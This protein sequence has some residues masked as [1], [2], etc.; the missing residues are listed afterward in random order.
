AELGDEQRLRRVT[1]AHLVEVG[2]QG[3]AVG[4]L[5]VVPAEVIVDPDDVERSVARTAAGERVTF[6]RHPDRACGVDALCRAR[7]RGDVQ[8]DAYVNVVF[9]L[10]ADRP[11]DHRGVVLVVEDVAAPLRD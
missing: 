8:T 3:V 10:V 11:D 9:Q 4:D 7:G 5:A 6:D 1:G 2:G